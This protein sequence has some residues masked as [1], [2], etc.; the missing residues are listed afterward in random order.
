MCR[1]SSHASLFPA[2][3]LVCGC[4]QM[5]SIRILNQDIDNVT[6]SQLLAGGVDRRFLIPMNVDVLMK[7]QRD[8]EF[9]N[10]ISD[11]RSEICLC[12][13]S[14]VMKMAAAM[15]LGKNF[16]FRERIS[17]SDYFPQFCRHHA[18]NQDVK[19][20]L[21]GAMGDVA[22]RAMNVINESVGRRIVVAAH[23]PSYG[24]ERDAEECRKIVSH[25]NQS[26]ATVLAIGVGA[27]KQELWMFRHADELPEI[28]LFL[29][30]GATIDFVAG[31][32]SRAPRWMSDYGLEWLYR[33]IV[34]PRRL[35][36]RYL[37]D[38]LPFFWLL[39]KQKLGLYRN[40]FG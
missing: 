17:G 25:V 6:S 1:R 19:I 40:P 24:F 21:L 20:F 10:A 22:S 23:S 4:F 28:G 18:S 14:Q 35:G 9:Y 26:G 32:V 16:H 36:K 7:L 33:L 2:A 37:V 39:M 13:D 29:A 31:N 38:D 12:Q 30:I 8:R 15:V 11:R 34:E 3:R 5:N 27:P